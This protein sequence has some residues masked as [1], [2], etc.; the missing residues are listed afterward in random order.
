MDPLQGLQNQSGSET[1]LFS[2][3]INVAFGFIIGLM[4]FLGFKETIDF[5]SKLAANIIK[6]TGMGQQMGSYGGFVSFAPYIV[7]APIGGLVVKQLSAVRSIKSFAFFA[8][9]VI[10]G[11]VIAF[12]GQGYFKS[13]IS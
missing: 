9:A 8:L 1:N 10:V 12:L 5:G 13:L 7:I 3:L 2:I 6:L 4:L 11:L